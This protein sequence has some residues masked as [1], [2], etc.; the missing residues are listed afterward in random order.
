[1]DGVSGERTADTGAQEAT[2]T[3]T[4]GVLT[5]PA[6]WNTSGRPFDDR[7]GVESSLRQLRAASASVAS[8]RYDGHDRLGSVFEDVPDDTGHW[9]LKYFEHT[10]DPLTHT[11]PDYV[12]D[13]TMGEVDEE[14]L[15][16]SMPDNVAGIVVVR[17]PQRE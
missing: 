1:M 17:V 7:P 14:Y 10:L 13:I 16:S 8:E 11:P 12:L 15:A 5:E 4:F 2:R 6:G 3:G 9:G